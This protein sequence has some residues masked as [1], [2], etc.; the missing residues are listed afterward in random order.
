[1]RKT[2][3]ILTILLQFNFTAFSQTENLDSQLFEAVKA[4]DLEQVKVLIEKGAHVNAKD[5]FYRFY[6]YNTP[7]HYTCK[8]KNGLEIAK[9]LIEKGAD[10]NIQNAKGCTTQQVTEKQEPQN[11]YLTKEQM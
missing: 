9:L 5:S 11:Y 8:N 10:V 3:I 6:Y 1:V 7:L 4:N 2:T